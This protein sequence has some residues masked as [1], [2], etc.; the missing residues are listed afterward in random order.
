M[1]P[2][3]VQALPRGAQP[4]SQP[5]ANQAPVAAASAPAAAVKP[6]EDKKKQPSKN[7]ADDWTEYKTP[8]GKVYYCNKLTR[9]TQWDK[10]EALLQKEAGG[11][12]AKTPWKEYTTAEGRKYYH[13][14]ITKQTV[15]DKPKELMGPNETPATPAAKPAAAAEAADAKPAAAA[16]A[17]PKPKPK[18]MATPAQTFELPSKKPEVT[19]VEEVSKGGRKGAEAIPKLAARPASSQATI[20]YSTKK[21]RSEAFKK[22][23]DDKKVDPDMR[24]E[25]AMKIIIN[26]ERYKAF[27]SVGERKATFQEWCD[28]KRKQLK[29]QALMDRRRAREDFMA[30]LSER[31]EIT[32][33]MSYKKAVPYIERDSR[34][35]A[36]ETERD[37][38][39]LFEDFMV[40]L[41]R[42]RRE[43]KRNMRKENMASFRQLLEET[44]SIKVS[45]QWRKVQE[46]LDEDPRYLALDKEDRLI[47]FEDYIRDMERRD[48]EDKIKEAE[49]KKKQERRVRDEFRQ[50]LQ[51]MFEE[52]Q[53]NHRTKWKKVIE[54]PM[55]NHPA[56]KAMEKQGR[57]KELFDDFV[58]DLEN[59]IKED[60]KVIKQIMQDLTFVITPSTTLDEFTEAIKADSKFETVQPTSVRAI[61]DDLQ[62]K[63]ESREKEARKQK[64][65]VMEKFKDQLK[66]IK[67]IDEH[68]TYEACVELFE[69]STSYQNLEDEERRKV[70]D[71]YVAKLKRK[72]EKGDK[73][74]KD[75]DKDRD[76][77]EKKKDKKHKHDH[78]D[79]PV[80]KRKHDDDDEE[81]DAAHVD[82]R[83][84]DRDRDRGRDRDRDRDRDHDRDHEKKE[85]RHKRDRGD[86]DGDRDRKRRREREP[87]DPED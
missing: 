53:L 86:D 40:D 72:Q 45:S 61:Y 69:D 38:E 3:G 39:N 18:P 75:K 26:D 4:T 29:E 1:P 21:E 54:G 30:M 2:N 8:E 10:P 79:R 49:E 14:P 87:E 71:E 6:E 62:D 59:S 64:Q 35:T 31:E 23:L 41:D 13:N 57:E 74:H 20:I 16:A 46:L 50:L 17:E 80:K 68:A 83:D 32:V 76:K 66:S 15:W 70:F 78:D 65:K 60:K 34:F 77:D 12:V 36:I 24:W 58:M 56:F 42:K 48:E 44:K 37:R 85:K 19:D 73:H 82:D 11:A 27:K 63:L 51:T 7:P 84:R 5:A 52:G 28:K 9:Q 33:N 81:E 55:K 25:E 67:E 47:V 43:D 22:L